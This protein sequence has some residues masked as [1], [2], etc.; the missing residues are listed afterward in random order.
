MITLHHIPGYS[1]VDHFGP[2]VLHRV[3]HNSG[4]I[5]FPTITA[6]RAAVRAAMAEMPD[7]MCKAGPPRIDGVRD[8]GKSWEWL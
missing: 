2:E 7:S 4:G 5:K 3:E 6:A 8:D 1:R